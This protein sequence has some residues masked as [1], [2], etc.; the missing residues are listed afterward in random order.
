MGILPFTLA[1]NNSNPVWATSPSKCSLSA[2]KKCLEFKERTEPERL[3]ERRRERSRLVL[4]GKE[5]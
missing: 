3:D 2:E 1:A 5:K 4:L